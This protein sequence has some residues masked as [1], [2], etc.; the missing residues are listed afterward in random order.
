MNANIDFDSSYL[1]PQ[2]DT[3]KSAAA[4]FDQFVHLVV[5]CSNQSHP[6]LIRGSAGFFL[7]LLVQ[8]R[9][10][11]NSIDRRYFLILQIELDFLI[12][13]FHDSLRHLWERPRTPGTFLNFSERTSLAWVFYSMTISLLT[14]GS[15]STI[16]KPTI[17]LLCGF[18]QIQVPALLSLLIF[19]F[20]YFWQARVPLFLQ[21]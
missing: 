11:F 6:E 12:P 4:F 21:L 10:P 15:N 5:V 16:I 19:S 7:P 8:F 14:K 17:Y 9:F 20:T 2:W 13:R 18:F 3:P 1:C